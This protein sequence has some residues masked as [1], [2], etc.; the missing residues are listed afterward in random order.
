MRLPDLKRGY[1]TAMAGVSVFTLS[2]FIALSEDL[3]TA[4]IFTLAII[5]VIAKV[6]TSI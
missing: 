2:A 4:Y 3:F 5:G 1:A 6:T